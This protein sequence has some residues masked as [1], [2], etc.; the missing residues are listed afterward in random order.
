MREVIYICKKC[1]SLYKKEEHHAVQCSQCHEMLAETS[2]TE[3]E[4]NKLPEQ[5]RIDI[6]K[7]LRSDR[8]KE[9][10]DIHCTSLLIVP[11][12]VTIE[13]KGIVTSTVVMGTGFVSEFDA[14]MSDMMGTQ[15]SIFEQKIDDAKEIAIQRLKEKCFE[16]GADAVVGVKFSLA[17]T[18]IKN[19][20]AVTADGTLVML[21]KN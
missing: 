7:A 9:L 14:K 15:A 1:G 8:A 13:S 16:K 18:A 5:D 21:E 10:A 3:D 11:G 19:L 20:L 12:Y 6:R 17:T 4:W 2:Y